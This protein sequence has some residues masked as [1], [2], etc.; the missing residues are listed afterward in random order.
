MDYFFSV[1]GR[2]GDGYSDSLGRAKYLAVPGSVNK[3]SRAHEIKKTSWFKKVQEKAGAKPPLK[4]H[5]VVFVHGFNTEQYDMLE[6]HR[7]IRKGLEA[8]GFKGTLVSF[9]WPSDGSALGY[10][11]DRRDA[12]LSADRLF[13]DGITRLSAM[14]TENCDFNVH[15]L[16][17]SM[18]CFLLREAFDYAD[19]DHKTA[20]KSWTVS[21]IALVA[22]DISQKSMIDGSSKSS[23]LL[24]HSTRVTSY[25]SPFD[26]ILSISEVKRIGVSRRLGR[27]GL[28]DAHSEKAVNL[29]CGA[30]FKQN[31][32]TFGDAVG[33]SHRWYFESQRFYEDLYHT[34][35]GKLDRDVIPTR[36][37][38][39]QGNLALT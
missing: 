22:A 5:I 3:V 29:Y 2:S 11:S 15:V 16:A 21:Q 7:K 4:G 1:R 32:E 30:Y 12:R 37:R 8:Q 10:S 35:M 28:P 39:D 36:G 14:Q 6:R 31:R 23:S 18:G 9:D 24:R 25:Y 17:H 33:M 26:D 13:Q 34:F 20:Q 19:D 38:S 27:V